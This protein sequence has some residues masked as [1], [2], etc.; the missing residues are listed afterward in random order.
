MKFVEEQSSRSQTWKFWS[1]YVFQ[2]CLAYIS[3]HLAIR[4]GNWSLRTAAIK[5][6]AAVFTAFDRRKYQML[7]AITDSLIPLTMQTVYVCT[8]CD[9]ISFFHGLGK[10]YFL[11]SLFEYCDLFV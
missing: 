7:A 10:A 4:T 11:N 2:D 1:Q 8:G 3:L 5:S 6:M 9:Y